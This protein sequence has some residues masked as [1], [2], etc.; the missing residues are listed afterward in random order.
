MPRFSYYI[1]P[2]ATPLSPASAVWRESLPLAR[3]TSGK[4]AQIVVSHGEYFDAIRSF[5][6]RDGGQ[7]FSGIVSQ[8]VQQTL[9]AGDIQQIRVHLEKH[10][11]FY[12]PARIETDAGGRTV[13]FVLNVAVSEPGKTQINGEFHNLK[14]LNAEFAES[15]L[16]QVYTWGE[17]TSGSRR[18]FRMFL[19]DWLQDY[20]EFHLARNTSD[21]RLKLAVWDDPNPRFFLSPRQ[22]AQLYRQVARILA[23]Y[24]NVTT[25]EQVFS[26]HH[27]AGDFVVRVNAPELDVK[28][29]TVRH[30]KSF[31]N[32]ADG[33]ED[34]S[35]NPEMILQ[36]LLIFFLSL[37]IRTRLDR[38][39]GVGELVWADSAAVAP[40]LTGFMEGLALKPPLRM[41]PDTIER[42]FR[43]YLAG[44][45]RQ[46]FDELSLA[47]AGALHPQAPEI[48]VI[49]QNLTGHVETLHAVV[50]QMCSK[51]LTQK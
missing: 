35:H 25:F 12:H 11:E 45:S 50:Q 8:R 33:L 32:N 31:L 15:F 34:V 49:K 23:Y 16:P 26:W 47:V 51:G 2:L 20:C 41:L 6:E 22:S 5:F 29:I 28:L 43:Y 4:S 13:S 7:M 38:L 39:D 10:G 24:Y 21:N 9:L 3:P 44:C 14:K 17:V 18:K 48:P 46:D 19:G 42:C 27:A 1:S 36:A 37:G 30:Y 40:T